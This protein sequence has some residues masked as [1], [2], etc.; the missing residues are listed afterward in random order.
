MDNFDEDMD[1]NSQEVQDIAKA[2]V[3]LVVKSGGDNIAYQKDKVNQWSQVI[4]E[5]CIKDLCK[6]QKPFK[7]SVTCIIM[8]N[9][10][11]GL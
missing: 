5:S 9:N 1:F 7:Y 2:A 4:I 6:L 3:E 10:G 8:Q 11:S